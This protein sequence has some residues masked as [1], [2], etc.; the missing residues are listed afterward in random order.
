MRGLDH[1]LHKKLPIYHKKIHGITKWFMVAQCS[2]L[3]PR[4]YWST[5]KCS[6]FHHSWYLL[7]SEQQPLQSE[8]YH[9]RRWIMVISN[10]IHFRKK[11]FIKCVNLAQSQILR[12]NQE[13]TNVSS[14][15]ARHCYTLNLGVWIYCDQFPSPAP[16]KTSATPPKCC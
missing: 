2:I 9:L 14:S 15:Y 12:F 8:N 6:K 3:L 4:S 11:N 10:H 13:S 5:S 16:A 1:Y 7:G